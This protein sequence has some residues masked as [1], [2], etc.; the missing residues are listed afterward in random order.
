MINDV[1]RWSQGFFDEIEPIKTR[2]PLSYILG[3]QAD[4]EPSYFYYTDAVKM[5]G[6]SCPAVSGAFRITQLALCALY[7][8]DE[9]PTR[10]EI[11]VLIK[12]GARDLAY[13][14]QAQVISLITGASGETGFKGL[15]GRF[16][17]N[18]RLKFDALDPQFC[19]YI[20]QREDTGKTVKVVY[21]PSALGTDSA[22][23]PLMPLVL[24]GTA[25]KEQKKLF[26]TLW[27]GKVRSIL[28]ENDKYPGLFTVEE[29]E[30][31]VYPE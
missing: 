20:F 13:G 12:G 1:T 14:P 4:E 19:T 27:Q 21:N 6:H 24:N 2:D 28:L 10:G 5:A 11:R 18:D 3:A 8:S 25:T 9:T 16:G 15:G 29:M 7:G 26:T 22:M 31:F 30:D 23:G 17:R